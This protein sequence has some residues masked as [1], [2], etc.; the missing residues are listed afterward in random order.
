MPPDPGLDERAERQHL[1]GALGLDVVEGESG[2]RAA[3]PWPSKAG[4]TSVWVETM[5]WS[6]SWHSAHP[7]SPPSM[8]AS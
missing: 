6:V 3:D 2:D 7:A 1:A 4:S 8:R 5:S